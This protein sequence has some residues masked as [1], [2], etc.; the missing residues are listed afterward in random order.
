MSQCGGT[1]L[2]GPSRLAHESGPSELGARL[3]PRRCRTRVDNVHCVHLSA[4]PN[5]GLPRAS[6]SGRSA[7]LA[8]GTVS[9]SLSVLH[10]ASPPL[11]AA[12]GHMCKWLRSS[13]DV[14]R[15]PSPTAYS[16]SALQSVS[17]RL[18]PNPI[19]A[20]GGNLVSALTS[21]NIISNKILASSSESPLRPGWQGGLILTRPGA[22]QAGGTVG[23]TN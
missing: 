3:L 11:G 23:G 8:I 6:G 2:N 15:R 14:T 1:A 10:I 20:R 12:S 18:R 19:S 7:L 16:S 21:A 17:T 22:L 4:L 13:R 5:R 9:R